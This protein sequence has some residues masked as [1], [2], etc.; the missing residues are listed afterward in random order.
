[1]VFA[2]GTVVKQFMGEILIGNT[3]IWR[4]KTDG[5]TETIRSLSHDP[6]ISAWSH[7]LIFLAFWVYYLYFSIVFSQLIGIRLLRIQWCCA[8]EGNI[9]FIRV[10]SVQIL[11]QPKNCHTLP[12]GTVFIIWMWSKRWPTANLSPL[13]LENRSN[14]W[15]P[16]LVNWKS[17]IWAVDSTY[18]ETINAD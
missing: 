1:M 4:K 5:T 10:T 16:G 3:L 14:V 6:W 17:I 7:E 2:V 12:Y 13:K 18:K 11:S 8:E 15:I 9:I